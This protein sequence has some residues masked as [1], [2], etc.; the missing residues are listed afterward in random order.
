MPCARS[1]ICACIFWP[2]L[3]IMA[4]MINTAFESLID[5][6]SPEY[7]PLA[8]AAKD[9]AAGSV[10]ISAL[11]SLVVA[12]LIFL[13]HI[14]SHI[15]PGVSNMLRIFNQNT[16]IVVSVLPAGIAAGVL[17][18]IAMQ[19]L[20]K[21]P[22]KSKQR[23]QE[24]R[25]VE[26]RREQLRGKVAVDIK[27]VVTGKQESGKQEAAAGK[28]ESKKQ[29][30]ADGKLEKFVQN[31]WNG[32]WRELVEKAK[33]AR[34]HAY[35]PYSGFVVGAALL[36]ARGK[37][38]TGC[39]VENASYGL[40]MCA[41][42]AAVFKAVAAGEYAFKAIA[43]AGG[44]EGFCFP[45]GACRQVLS[46]FCRQKVECPPGDKVECSNDIEV[47]IVNNRGD[48]IVRRLSELLPDAFS[49]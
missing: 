41:E 20:G 45:C 43:V 15:F 1:A 31:K 4:E 46:E 40:S 16:L 3:V 13:P 23:P 25:Q 36:T 17:S 38:Y 33:E 42:R 34:R 12:S 11:N 26:R 28:Q 39:N 8:G 44:R 48:I 18:A 49:L 47:I 35:A 27:E 9:V 24:E 32:R 19:N 6:V 2:T 37:I 5:I 29:E 14:F 7:H 21:M 30:A 10:L 22:V